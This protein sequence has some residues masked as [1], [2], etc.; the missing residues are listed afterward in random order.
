[1]SGPI[2]KTLI[3]GSEMSERESMQS[4]CNGLRKSASCAREM[5]RMFSDPSWEETAKLLDGMRE[6]GLA[7]SK[8]RAMTRIDVDH[9]INLKTNLLLQ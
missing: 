4:F 2:Q 5:A 9:A 7:L 3:N 6:N 1:M 8:M